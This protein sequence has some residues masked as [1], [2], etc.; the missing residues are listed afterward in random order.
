MPHSGSIF[1]VDCMRVVKTEYTLLYKSVQKKKRLKLMNKITINIDPNER[2][3]FHLLWHQFNICATNFHFPPIQQS[4]AHHYIGTYIIR[5][6]LNA[7]Q[8][9]MHINK[10]N[11]VRSVLRTLRNPYLLLRRRVTYVNI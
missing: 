8:I 6:K 10:K 5:S 11:C 7:F 2:V 3:W 4:P 9:T 1:G